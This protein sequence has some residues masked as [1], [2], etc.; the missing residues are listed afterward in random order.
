VL[1]TNKIPSQHIALVICSEVLKK[2][3]FHTM[4][5]R[6]IETF[7][8]GHDKRSFQGGNSMSRALRLLHIGSGI[9]KYCLLLVWHPSKGS[10][11]SKSNFNS[12]AILS[13][14]AA[15]A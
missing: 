8:Y 6:N 5:S 1:K 3:Y 2:H 15:K 14:A 13:A 9:L 12:L 7:Y 11:H 10:H 4:T